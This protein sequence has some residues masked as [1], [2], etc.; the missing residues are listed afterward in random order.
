MA[1]K[2]SDDVNRDAQM[3]IT[4][5]WVSVEI[6]KVEAKEAVVWSHWNEG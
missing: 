5:C 2:K 6:A 1:V 3:G 4:R